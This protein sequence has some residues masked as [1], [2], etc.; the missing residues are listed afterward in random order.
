MLV[1]LTSVFY[2]VSSSIGALSKAIY[3]RLFIWLVQRCNV[4]LASKQDPML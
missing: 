1:K 4:T 3:D 2:Q